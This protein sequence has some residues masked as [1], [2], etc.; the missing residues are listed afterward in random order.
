MQ[1][2]GSAAMIAALVNNHGTMLAM[3]YFCFCLL[4]IFLQACDSHGESTIITNDANSPVPVSLQNGLQTMTE[5]R[6]IGYTTTKFP[7]RS[8]AEA[9]ALV[10]Y[11]AMHKLCADEVAFNARAAFSE[12]AT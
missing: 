9:G 11:A 5:Y 12:E 2:F 7:G 4:I 10:G 3:K 1:G 6:I 8:E